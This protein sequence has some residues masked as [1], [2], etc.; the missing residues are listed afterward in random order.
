M[1]EVRVVKDYIEEPK[2]DADEI[3]KT[4]DDAFK[5]IKSIES[6]FF[7]VRYIVENYERMN[8]RCKKLEDICRVGT[9]PITDEHRKFIAKSIYPTNAGGHDTKIISSLEHYK[10]LEELV[11][12]GK[13]DCWRP[14]ISDKIWDKVIEIA[15]DILI[16]ELKRSVCLLEN[17]LED[18]LGI[19]II[20]PAESEGEK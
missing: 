6:D 3:M 7:H 5:T 15:K 9:H 4:L 8:N 2:Y 12:L 19:L 20:N 1:S 10:S 11:Y 18:P 16:K 17:N 13:N 14:Y